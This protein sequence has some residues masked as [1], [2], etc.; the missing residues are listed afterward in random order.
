MHAS[1][2]TERFADISLSPSPSPSPER[3]QDD[4]S[5]HSIPLTHTLTLIPSNVSGLSCSS[6]SGLVHSRVPQNQGKPSIIDKIFTC[7]RHRKALYDTEKDPVSQIA[8]SYKW[9]A[10]KPWHGWEHV[11]LG[12]WFNLLFLLIPAS[13]IL[14][15]ATD[16][17]HS[18]VFA[19]CVLSMIPL[20]KLHDLA[21]HELSIRLG[22]SKTGLLNASMSNIVEMVVAITAL[23]KCE[24]RV[25][26]SSLIGS[27]LSKLLLILGMC[28][29]AGGLRFT[30][31]GFDPTATQIHSSLLSISVGAVLLPAAFHFA[32]T[33]DTDDEVSSS[34][35]LEKQKQSILKMSRGVAIVLLFIYIS[36][37]IF[38]FWSHSHLY[39]DDRVNTP[40]LQS[41]ASAQSN[42][43][44]AAFRKSQMSPLSKM[45]QTPNPQSS[46]SHPYGFQHS[47]LSQETVAGPEY[48][49]KLYTSRKVNEWNSPYVNKTHSSSDEELD[50]ASRGPYLVSPFA[51]TSQFTLTENNG[52]NGSTVRLVQIQTNDEQ[53]RRR[54]STF[55]HTPSSY[56]SDGD[57]PGTSPVDEVHTPYLPNK[58][59]NVEKEKHSPR[60]VYGAAPSLAQY[61]SE[62]LHADP[63]EVP[64]EVPKMSWTLTIM[65][66][67]FVTILVAINAEWLVDSMDEL[68]PVIS[69]E[70]IALIL[71]PAVGS[72][73]EC[74]T[75]VNVSVKDKLTLSV[76]VAVGS[77]IQTA[78]F[79]IPFMVL[80]GWVMD[81]PLA[82][83][84]DPFESVV[85]YISVHT[86][87]YVVADGRSNWLEGVIL[88]CLY[89]VVAVSFWFYP[90]SNFSTNLAVCSTSV[91]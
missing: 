67:L 6:S 18:I 83:L 35:P 89:V 33:Y 44:N 81:K 7:R 49:G 50:P 65:V 21:T 28:F 9:P 52:P 80:L 31:Q 91:F 4:R 82:L 71:L 5:R 88:V 26:Q 78:L 74:I 41:S 19:F 75:A 12:S 56:M 51:T 42:A 22:G 30:E 58:G 10:M 73:A 38:Q 59:R 61:S 23:R 53:M 66:L 11:V 27:M 17:T 62:P 64:I 54:R 72:L 47:V 20:V 90:G 40:Q 39:K 14:M 45:G 55:S 79:V 43:S 25:V 2:T 8:D 13:W 32:L 87:G 37:L 84:F 29:F 57:S 68:S 69:K 3:I 1:S 60:R 24:L 46:T 85:L 15:L 86:M 63:V 76:S 77:T 34:T 36:Y 70:W 16:N 48:P